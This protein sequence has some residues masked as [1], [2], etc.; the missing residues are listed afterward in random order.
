MDDDDHAARDVTQAI[1]DTCRSE[2][3][4]KKDLPALSRVEF[5]AFN[6][7]RAAQILHIGPFSEEGPTIKSFTPSSE[8]KD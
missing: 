1:V 5:A 2:L 4:R 7:G 3:T 6:E 8:P